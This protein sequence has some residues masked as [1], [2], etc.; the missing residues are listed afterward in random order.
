LCVA[1]WKVILGQGTI[2]M[3]LLEQMNV[4]NVVAS[5]GG[6]GLMSGIV[7]CYRVKGDTQ[8]KYGTTRIIIVTIIAQSCDT[9]PE[10][11]VCCVCCVCCVCG[12]RFYSVET[13]GADWFYQS[14]EAGQLVTLPT[15]TSIAKTLGAKSST[16][17]VYQI[18]SRNV[19][20]A[21]RVSDKEAVEALVAFL[22]REKLLVEPAA[23]CVVAAVLKNPDLFAGKSTVLIVCGSNT[24]LDEVGLWRQQFNM[25]AADPTP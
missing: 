9:I 20:R 11:V 5:V 13:E 3:E 14:S 15:I 16:P 12:A 10:R 24:T 17:E 2:A 8:T 6:G 19:E 23:A 7:S 18:L 25:F 4:D 21:L 22:D 1:F